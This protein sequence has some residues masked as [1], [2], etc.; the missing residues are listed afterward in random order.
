M[1]EYPDDRVLIWRRSFPGLAEHVRQAREF[2]GFLLADLPRVDD[3]VLVVSEFA[4]NALRHTA[5]ARPGGHYTLEVRRWHDGAS[6]SL[7]DE[8]SRKVPRVPD[9]GDL[10]ECGRGLQTVE[11]IASE[12]HWTGDCRGRTFTATFLTRA[13]AVLVSSISP[14]EVFGDDLHPAAVLTSDSAL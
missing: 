12:W 8:G 9:L 13:H 5:S 2:A 6:V 14:C 3:V 11:A 10:A 4:A 7:T 1:E